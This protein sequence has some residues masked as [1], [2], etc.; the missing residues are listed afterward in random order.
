MSVTYPRAEVFMA[1]GAGIL[2][3]GFAPILVR[4]APDTSPL[5]LTVM[6][7]VF[8]ALLLLPY[9]LIYRA[10]NPKPTKTSTHHPK[11]VVLAGA[12]L[13]LHFTLWISSLYFTTVASTSV[14]VTTHPIIL[15]LVESL[16]MKRSFRKATWT[17]VFLAFGGA[18]FLGIADSQAPQQAPDPL[19]GN[20][21][22]FSAAAVFVIYIL[23]G[24]RIRQERE[25]IDYVFP[26]YSY[27][28]VTCLAMAVV[29][30]ENLLLTNTAGVLAALAL[31]A[32]PQILGHG[33]MNYAVKFISPT[34]LSTLV[35]AEPLI[36]T[37]AAYFF[38]DE[39]PPVI[40]IT[41]MVIILI[42]ITLTWRRRISS[43]TKR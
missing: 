32:G 11:L 14:L 20:I 26:V 10:K 41:A 23:I 27:A 37:I 24:Q 40:S 8:A 34:L 1:L 15:I 22:A 35:L 16:L 12:C 3:F 18:V 31:A 6:R 13:G 29:A 28:A 43:R 25:W 39:L 30:G 21:L 2:S 36:A 5:L 38:F 4:L 17:G 42:G 19:L 33:S 7:T 9:W